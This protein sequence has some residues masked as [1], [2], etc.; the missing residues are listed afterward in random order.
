MPLSKELQKRIEER[1]GRPVK[2]SADC[3]SL[4]TC[5]EVVTKNHIGV[6]TVKRMFGLVNEAPTPRGT[7]MDQIAQYLGYKDMKDMARMLGD[8]SDISMFAAVDELDIE[9]L[10]PGTLIQISYDPQRLIV[11]DYMGDNW[12]I[13]N[14]SQNCKLQK[15]DKV[16]IF[17]L[18]KGFELLASEVIRDGQSLGP[19]H[20]AKDGGLT[21]IEI[22]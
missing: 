9:H 11:M 21:L 18:A 4:A 1:F 20:S 16:R 15:G 22:I 8:A 2:C 19:Y 12:F 3:E 6:T 13:I 10:E 14:E 5:I 17:Q 7:T